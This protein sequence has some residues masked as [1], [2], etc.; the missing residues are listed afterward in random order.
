LSQL[1]L[2]FE[3]VI[4]P[5]EP[6]PPSTSCPTPVDR[7]HW[8]AAWKLQWGA[9]VA[10]DAVLV[11]ADTMVVLDEAVLGKPRNPREAADMLR[12]LSGRCHR[13]ITAVGVGA[14]ERVLLEHEE[15]AVVMRP[16]SDEEISGYVRSG[17]PLDKAGAYGIQGLG[18]VLV[19][20][21]E[22][23]FYNVVG[24]PL[25][26][27]ARMLEQFDIRVLGKRGGV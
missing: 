15:T 6:E 20:R 22:G 17:E 2:H 11:A 21:I 8:L 24:L 14:G 18:A 4:P 26:R 9:S 25:A 12:M 10:P 7:A 13:V 5:E 23:C 19:E 1:G 27:L 3:V 16:L